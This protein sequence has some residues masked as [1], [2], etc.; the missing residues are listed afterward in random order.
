MF[1]LQLLFIIFYLQQRFVEY[2]IIKDIIQYIFIVLEKKRAK[3]QREEEEEVGKEE[4]V[5]GGK[6]KRER[7]G[8]EKR[9][10]E[11]G[12]KEIN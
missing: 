8:G 1:V 5:E 9:E 4:E 3:E 7:G 11:G 10:E 6:E 2:R 12:Y